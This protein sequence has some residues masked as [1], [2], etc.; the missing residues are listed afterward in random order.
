MPGEAIETGG[1][2]FV[3]PLAAIAPAITKLTTLGR[4]STTAN[5]ARPEER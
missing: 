4:R 3:L 5:D 2:T 1:V